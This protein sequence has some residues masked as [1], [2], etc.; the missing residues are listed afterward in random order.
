MHGLEISR[1]LIDYGRMEPEKATELFIR[2]ALVAAEARLPHRFFTENEKVREKIENALTRVRSRRAHDLDESLYQYYAA[3]LHP[4]SSVHDLNRHG[5][6]A[7][8]A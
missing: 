6:R 1:G 8:R 3:R 4:V 7:H 2:G 5:A